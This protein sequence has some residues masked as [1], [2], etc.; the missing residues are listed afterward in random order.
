[1]ATVTSAGIGSNL[2]VE[3]IITK[4]MAVEQLPV[5][6]LQTEA[7]K[8]QTKISAYGS[9]QSSVAGFRDAALALTRS[10]TWGATAATSAD[11]SAVSVSGG[12]SASVGNFA[13]SVQSLAAAQSAA[14]TSFASSSA[15]VGE[16]SLTIDTGSWDIGEP[17][18]KA[19]ATISS[20]NIAISATDTLA[21]V[22]DKINAAGG[23]V[24]ASIVTDASGARLVLSSKSTGVENGFRVTAS[25][26][27]PSA[28]AYDAT[29]GSA[30]MTRTQTASDAKAKINGLE[31]TSASNTLNDVVQGLTM[32]LQKVTTGD[33]QVS[34]AQ[35]NTS[36]KSAITSFVAAYNG[37][38]S[39]L[40]SQTKYDESSKTAGTLQGDSTAVSLQRQLR[41][42]LTGTGT[43]SSAFPTLSSIGLEIQ[44]DGTLKVSDTKLNSA[45]GNLTE[46][47]KAFANSDTTDSANDGFAQKLR[48]LGDQVLGT[49][50]SLAARTTGL[51]STLK[52]NQERQDNITD[53]MTA[54]EKRLRAQYTAL[55]TKMA[56][57]NTLSTYIT[58]Q[59]ANWNKSTG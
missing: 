43:A 6:Q 30:A 29:D 27:G 51:N 35:D 14:S 34:V 7:S 44:T 13:V 28:F 57:L 52:D 10:G 53:R 23:S 48:A 17:G 21:D 25:G 50:G 31:I 9:I 18:F 56:G 36:I 26:T 45:L 54:T 1:M 22:R 55:D 11:P 5:T 3:S 42:M 58:Q 12:S 2:P 49:D 40:R 32:N 8:I 46:M 38:S 24:A 16:G 39:L 20:M 59:I 15:V 19:R 33:V 4:L 41:S 37:L 47:K